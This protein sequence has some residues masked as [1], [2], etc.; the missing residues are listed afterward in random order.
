[1]TQEQI[2]IKLLMMLED[3]IDVGVVAG[4]SLMFQ[5]GCRISSILALTHND[6]SKSGRIILK[7]GKGSEPMVIVPCDFK[8]WWQCFRKL[9]LHYYESQN[10]TYYYRLFKKYKLTMSAHFGVK[11]AVTA[12]A[13]KMVAEDTMEMSGDLHTAQIALGHKSIKSTQYY[14]RKGGKSNG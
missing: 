5:S 12:S 3:G 7:Q 13:R 14:V 6:V 9:K 1:M 11:N 8:D 4:I 10:Y 2:E